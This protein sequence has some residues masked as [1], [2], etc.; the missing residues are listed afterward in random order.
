MPCCVPSPSPPLACPCPLQQGAPMLP[1]CGV[2]PLALRPALA[3]QRLPLPPLL[4]LPTA[5]PGMARALP[6][7]G[8]QQQR[9][10]PWMPLCSWGTL[11]RALPAGV[12]CGMRA[13]TC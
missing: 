11:Q 2:R 9:R 8:M 6:P 13:C 4:S 12:P 3:P 10:Q 1:S 5:C 7:Q